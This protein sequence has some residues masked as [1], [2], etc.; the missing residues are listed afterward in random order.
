MDIFNEHEKEMLEKCIK[1]S[2]RYSIYVDNDSIFVT[3]AEDEDFN[4]SFNS[5]GYYF[6]HALLKHLGCNV[7]YV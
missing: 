6:A 2:E 7:D 4:F 1:A 5:Y 3:D